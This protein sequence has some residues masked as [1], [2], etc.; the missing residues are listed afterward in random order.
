MLFGS[1][2]VLKNLQTARDPSWNSG[3][4][5]RFLSGSHAIG[6]PS[7]LGFG[8]RWPLS[9]MVPCTGVLA[10]SFGR[11]HGTREKGT[12]RKDTS[13]RSADLLWFMLIL[14]LAIQIKIHFWSRPELSP[15]TLA[16]ANIKVHDWS[17]VLGSK[18]P[19]FTLVWHW[20][21][22]ICFHLWIGNVCLPT[23]LPSKYLLQVPAI[24]ILGNS[25]QNMSKS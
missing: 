1:P 23:K 8:R 21:A 6:F 25:G 14:I 22:Q 11:P 20:Q 4:C 13:T 16:E 18:R 15:S 2:W 3:E 12:L 19:I 24:P 10:S 5:F 17:L 7:S 9:R